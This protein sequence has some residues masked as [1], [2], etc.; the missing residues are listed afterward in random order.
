M[1]SR[2]DLLDNQ[3]RVPVRGLWSVSKFKTFKSPF[4]SKHAFTQNTKQ[5]TH[6]T[7][8]TC[9]NCNHEVAVAVTLPHEMHLRMTGAN[10]LPATKSILPTAEDKHPRFEL[11]SLP[12]HGDLPLVRIKKLRRARFELLS[13]SI[14]II[15]GL[16]NFLIWCCE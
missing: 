14:I 4:K 11:P 1:G 10:A 9:H 15:G 6:A 16:L 8:I 3:L 13:F 7:T 5:A 2:A 12:L